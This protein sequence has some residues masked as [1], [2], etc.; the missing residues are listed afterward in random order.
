MSD[1]PPSDINAEEAVIGAIL[2]DPTAI[3]IAAEILEPRDFYNI[4]LQDIYAAA[5][6]LWRADLLVDQITVT[7]ELALADKLDAM[8]GSG[9]LNRLVSE[10]ASTVHVKYY[11]TIIK[12]MSDMRDAIEDM[13]KGIQELYQCRSDPETLRAE[14]AEKL[15]RD[16]TQKQTWQ[17]LGD[18]MNFNTGEPGLAFPW[19]SLN[20]VL[21]GLRRGKLYLVA[22]RPSQGKS[23][24][25]QN[26][27][28]FQ[29]KQKSS[30]LIATLE[31]SSEG[32]ADRLLRMEMGISDTRLAELKANP[33]EAITDASGRL[34][35]LNIWASEN[36]DANNA[37]ARITAF[38]AQR[39]ADIVIVD[40]IQL[41]AAN[42]K[43]HSRYDQVS[44]MSIQLARMAQRLEVPV[45]AVSQLNRAPDERIDHRPVLS[46]L[47][48]SGQLEQDA[49]AVIFLYRPGHYYSEGTKDWKP[50]YRYLLNVIVAKNKDG[51]T[52]QIRLNYDMPSG[53]IRS[54]SERSE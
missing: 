29:A 21:N 50:E 28:L 40:Y 45:I 47:R 17:R 46:D 26:I 44:D 42:T 7:H 23:T 4:T 30:I 1:L 15:L 39:P 36:L 34:G 19:P 14:V 22:G 53:N 24:F 37:I 18:V 43:S 38:H 52:G 20:K 5:L 41:F 51:P 12:Q 33:N 25:A 48:E 27:A 8:G 54:W 13:T 11:A 35:D 9:R 6:K 31:D 49:H 10:I 3:I 16:R 2:L 32:I